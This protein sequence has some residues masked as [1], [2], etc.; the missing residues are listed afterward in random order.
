MKKNDIF[1]F[2]APN[3][4]EVKAVCLKNIGT[5]GNITQYLC[6]GQNRLFTMNEYYSEWTEETGEV[7]KDSYI[8]YGE[9]IVDYAILPD[10]DTVL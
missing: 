3:G 10:Y 6:Y 1:T 7:C 4:V 8:E 9:V 2:I 5:I